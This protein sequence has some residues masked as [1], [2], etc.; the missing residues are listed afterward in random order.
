MDNGHPEET[1]YSYSIV[2]VTL[3]DSILDMY[4]VHKIGFLKCPATL[5]KNGQELGTTV[6]TSAC[7][8]PNMGPPI[9]TFDWFLK[10]CFFF[11]FNSLIFFPQKTV[12]S[13]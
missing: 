9:N 6:F 5:F 2:I 11:F 3:L 4:S 10:A 7:H 12:T 1:F 13:H 8:R